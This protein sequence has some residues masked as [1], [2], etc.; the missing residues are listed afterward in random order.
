MNT[1]SEKN[2]RLL[3]AGLGLT[4]F[5]TLLLEL[6]LTRIYSFILWYHFAFMS[7]SLALFG[8]S[9][10]GV[11]HYLYPKFVEGE[12][13]PR[14]I[15]RLNTIFGVSIAFLL[16]ALL[17]VK[18]IPE[19]TP[20]G[21]AQ[22]AI[23][24]FMSSVPFF[25]SG[26]STSVVLKRQVSRVNTVYF[27]DLFGA[28]L[29]CIVLI[30][31]LDILGGIHAAML[32]AVIAASGGVFYGLI[33]GPKAAR[34]PIIAVASLAVVFMGNL[35]FGFLDVRYVKGYN[36]AQIFPEPP[37]YE[38]WNSFSRVAVYHWNDET[39]RDFSLDPLR[40]NPETQLLAQQREQ[41]ISWGRSDRYVGE[42]PKQLNMHIDGMAGTM[43]NRWD[44]D[45]ASVPH[46]KYEITSV[47][48]YLKDGQDFDALIIGPGGGNDVMTALHYGAKHITAVE[49]NP[50]IKHITTEV[51]NDFTSDMNNRPNVD[52]HVDEGRSFIR[53]SDDTYDIIQ[54]SLIDTWAATA[55]G[56]YTLSEN[57]LY[58][59]E[60]FEDYLAHLK[61]DGIVAMAR[62]IFSP[63]RQSLRVANLAMTA[64]EQAGKE[65][66]SQHIMIFKV[67]D[68]AN[69]LVKKS[70]FTEAE[71]T[72]MERRTQEI[73]FEIVYTPRTHN[74]LAF[75]NVIAGPDRQ[76][77]IEEYPFDISASYDDR[78]FFFNMVRPQDWWKVLTFQVDAKQGRIEGGQSFN[79]D[80]VYILFTLLF[81]AAF[82]VALFILGPVFLRSNVVDG[83]GEG[84]TARL[85][86][87]FSCLGLGFMLIEIALL[88][89]FVLFLGHPVYALAVILFSVLLSSSL[90]SR[91]AQRFPLEKLHITMAIAIVG[92][93]VISLIYIGLFPSIFRYLIAL[94]TFVKILMTVVLLAPLGFL[95]GM[96]FPSG[97]RL[98]A[99]HNEEY[100]PWAW[101]INGSTSVLGSIIAFAWALA[102]GYTATLLLGMVIYLIGAAVVFVMPAGE[103]K[104]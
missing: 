29:G 92:I 88:Q 25:F 94:P 2:F 99:S 55:A 13:W 30:P 31:I 70:P 66:P 1:L 35:L 48:Y 63:P 100:L 33:D 74:N 102:Y 26:L 68:V 76:A 104:S 20:T 46:L 50:L 78:P 67:K 77:Y 28:A 87:Y 73:G 56:A 95:M 24:Y 7:V 49:L 91:Y 103:A 17:S 96:P 61:D 10:G 57:T 6:T 51:V 8:L 15:A 81:W 32:L 62:Y 27:V 58:T 84:L 79:Y 39:Y 41:Y 37:I 93:A 45:P 85:V 64:L 44:G 89:K 90:G 36:V 38:G 3:L 19:V 71:I 101:G 86:G 12:S 83:G 21:M 97:L 72:D 80:A 9:A 65:N 53:R 5:S 47:G 22:L 75:F 60:A 4:T 43:I 54:A 59:V 98:L 82:L 18:W 23:L 11:L 40:E 42:Y 52:Y 16:V 69:I 14:Q 34:T